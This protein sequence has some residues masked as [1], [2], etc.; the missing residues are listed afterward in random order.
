MLTSFGVETSSR[1][2]GLPAEIRIKIYRLVFA[3]DGSIVIDDLH[4][5]DYVNDKKAGRAT[6]TSYKTKD[7]TEVSC[8]RMTG[9]YNQQCTFTDPQWKNAKTSYA[10]QPHFMWEGPYLALLATNCQIR[11]EA[12][13]IFYG[14]HKFNICSMSALIPFLKDRSTQSLEC[15]KSFVFD[16]HIEPG[17]QQA[18]RQ[19]AWTQAFQGLSQFPD[20][21]IRKLDL[22]INDGE[23]G[24]VHSLKLNTK[25]MQWVHE[26]G[27][28]ITTLDMLGVH[29]GYELMGESP[30][31][32]EIAEGS[33]SQ[34]RLWAFLAPKMLRKFGDKAHD[35]E[36][37]KKR[38]I[39]D[40][41]EMYC[42]MDKE[43]N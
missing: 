14:E 40:G 38:R 42:D 30:S 10:F 15:L 37:L 36:S 34:E 17:K 3:P 31:D 24:Y 39:R 22:Y 41:W 6:R 35:A 25:M 11:P 4:P 33:T 12:I 27:N 28:N 26:L 29:I 23:M 9:M 7:H 18:S 8:P 16:L 1:L 32:D 21:V 13:P 19:K 2:V 43:W 5:E 20:L